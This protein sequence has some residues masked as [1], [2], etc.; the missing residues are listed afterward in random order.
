MSTEHTIKAYRREDDNSKCPWRVL[1][2]GKEDPLNRDFKDKQDIHDWFDTMT[3][4]G[5]YKDYDLIFISY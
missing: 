2:N 5:F 3:A 4:N 1:I